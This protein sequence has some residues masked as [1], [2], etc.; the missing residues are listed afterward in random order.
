MTER[1]IVPG[2]DAIPEL[3]ER[4]RLEPDRLE[5]E[6]PELPRDERLPEPERLELLPERLLDERPERL[7]LLPDPLLPDP[8]ALR[9]PRLDERS[10]E[11]E[12]LLDPLLEFDDPAIV[13]SSMMIVGV[14]RPPTSR[15]L[16]GKLV[17][18][19]ASMS[20]F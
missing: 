11:P 1:L 15:R 13:V 17:C 14:M 12:P 6:R 20:S 18:G 10:L 2:I 8:D 3:D 19:E 9:E 16:L 7:P 5:L 4:P